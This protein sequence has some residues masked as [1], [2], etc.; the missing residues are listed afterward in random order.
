MPSY[1]ATSNNDAI[2]TAEQV[3]VAGT[4][5]VA[6]VKDVLVDGQS[7][8]ENDIAN[9][10]LSGKQDKLTVS[11]DLILDGADLSV[12]KEKIQE[13]LSAGEN[14]SIDSNTISAFKDKILVVRSGQTLNEV[15]FDV[16]S[17]QIIL[18]R[19]PDDSETLGT[20]FTTG[21]SGLGTEGW[22]V[23]YT[24][25]WKIV[26]ANIDFEYT[27][28]FEQFISKLDANAKNLA[29]YNQLLN[30]PTISGQQVTGNKQLSDYGSKILIVKDT[31]TIDFDLTSTPYA[32]VF[33][34]SAATN[35]PRIIVQPY[36]NDLTSS[37]VF[38]W[39]DGAWNKTTSAIQI[40]QFKTWEDYCIA[41]N[42]VEFVNIALTS[43]IKIDS[44]A[45]NGTTV[46]PDTDKHVN[47]TI[48]KSTV[49]LSN[50][51]NT[52]DTDKP[53]STAQQAAIDAVDNKLNHRVLVDLS[54]QEE[55][56]SVYLGTSSINLSTGAKSTGSIEIISGAT[57]DSAGLMT[58]ADV[59][60]LSDLQ[61]RVG[62]LE[63]RTTRL[64]YTEKTDP[65]ADEINAF[66][67]GLGYTAPFD[68][69]AVVI[70]GTYHIWHYY[71][72]G[73]VGWRD[74]GQDTVSTFTNAVAGIIKGAGETDGKIYAE[75]DGTGSVYGWDALKTQVSTN[76][77]N[78]NNKLNKVT[79]VTSYQQVYTKW[80]DGTNSMLNADR[81]ALADALIIRDG[82]GRAKAAAGISDDDVVNLKQLNDGLSNKLDK[83][84]SAG[85]TRVYSITPTGEQSTFEAT[86]STDA[87]SIALRDGEGKLK[88]TAGTDNDDVV[89]FAQLNA[90]IMAG[91]NGLEHTDNKVSSITG[92]GSDI[93]YPNTK[94]V[95]D[96]TTSA[97]TAAEPYHIT[98]TGTSGTLTDEQ[99]DGLISDDRSYIVKDTNILN[100]VYTNTSL[101]RWHYACV[102]S[103]VVR[104]LEFNN[105]KAWSYV[106]YS[107][108]DARKL[109]TSLSDSSTDIQYPSAKAVVDYVKA[110]A[111]VEPYYIELA[112]SS[113][114]ITSEQYSALLADNNSYI[115]RA[116]GVAVMR[117]VRASSAGSPD[118]LLIYQQ[119]SGGVSRTITIQSSGAWTQTETE[120]QV[121][122][123][124]TTI[125][126]SS[127]DTSYPSAKATYD[128]GQTI[129]TNAQTYANT[130]ETN[131]KAYAD[132]I[133]GSVNDWLQKIDTGMGV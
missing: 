45:L 92:E 65:T 111:G 60:T 16:L 41:L 50:V 20:I 99:Y 55:S 36:Y 127:T 83:I 61:T 80:Q 107:L 17:D 104:F 25:K 93:Q 47:I 72:N 78:L 64:L 15:K 123:L 101:N 5:V 37:D 53:V 132:E 95:I 31:D 3:L 79:T 7:V 24:S 52:S 86:N 81:S 119:F 33:I 97:I 9:I 88:A 117:Y 114:T 56:D 131:A 62:N 66:V 19:V 109:V 23:Q 10:D 121:D 105:T 27:D 46:A 71:S 112:G 51:D 96:Y 29:D 116:V 126:S 130:A 49:G 39:D 103:N 40:N 76:E 74:D 34:I 26:T 133:L 75:T 28:T 89:N 57:Q 82:Q 6:G 115:L 70:Q 124:T 90:A 30:L 118:N 113:G 43:D 11:D 13:K 4:E 14:I 48:D 125:S 58:A 68:G 2:E 129:Q 12:N 22:L 69:I 106:E 98:L 102:D 54:V 128:Y 42:A 21:D 87:N 77:S 84:T 8:V 38:Y 100:L 85:V 120:Y 73:N 91:V 108:Q 63:G 44:I 1:L 32:F 59:K 35:S 122:R 18:I 94:A 67:T 110:N